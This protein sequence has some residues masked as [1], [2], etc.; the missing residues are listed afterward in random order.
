MMTEL[1]ARSEP[2]QNYLKAIYAVMDGEHGAS[3]IDIASHV[4]VS[5]S[6]VSKML[7]QLERHGLITYSP[8]RPV[9]LTDLGRRVALEIIR[10]HRLLELYLMRSLGF[11]WEQVHQEAERLEHHISEE[12]EDSIDR[13]LGYPEYD[14]HGD[15]IPT[16]DGRV[17]PEV[18]TTLESQETG[19]RMV[20]RRVTDGD[21]DLL[22]YLGER[23]LRPG[24]AIALVGREPFGGSLLV[25]VNDLDIRVSPE[26]GKHIF[27]DSVFYV[28]S[29]PEAASALSRE[30][31]EK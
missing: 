23:G 9:H 17:P 1:T 24:V 2:V 30:Q 22:R 5:Q 12:F 6:G 11:T 7:R 31:A 27:V 25:Q 21:G 29:S 13:M 8:Y 28:G 4:G 3:Q 14:P 15:P 26:A 20:I 10:H 18:R 19:T 16:R